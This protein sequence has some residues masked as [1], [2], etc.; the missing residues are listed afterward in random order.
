MNLF[1]SRISLK[2]GKSAPFYLGPGRVFRQASGKLVAEIHVSSECAKKL[3]LRARRW[4]RKSSVNNAVIFSGVFVA[5][6]YNGESWR[7]SLVNVKI[8]SVSSTGGVVTLPLSWVER[9]ID[10][11][12]LDARLTDE[13]RIQVKKYAKLE[14][15]GSYSHSFTSV[16]K[17]RLSFPANEF[18]TG[19]TAVGDAKVRSFSGKVAANFSVGGANFSIYPDEGER[20]VLRG[21]GCLSSFSEVNLRHLYSAIEYA[22]GQRVVVEEF[23]LFNGKVNRK[24]VLSVNYDV[25][26]STRALHDASG[27]RDAECW[28]ILNKF[29]EFV[30]ADLSQSRANLL[31]SHSLLLDAASAPIE[32]RILA[33]C[34]SIEGLAS[35]LNIRPSRRFSKHS[36]RALKNWLK[37]LKAVAKQNKDVPKRVYDRVMQRIDS[38][39]AQNKTNKLS[40]FCSG[41]GDAKG[42]Y[43]LWRKWRHPVAHGD[44]LS[45]EMRARAR[46]DHE[47]LLGLFHLIVRDIIG[48]RREQGV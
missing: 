41:C 28:H 21:E 9:V 11:R 4:S 33:L 24:R 10:V 45:D 14:Q 34:T 19:N 27:V 37:A 25:I 15:D 23:T 5:R 7:S 8:P 6:G 29:Y 12:R 17:G 20:T 16:I 3:T 22:L 44:Q 35:K 32:V 48:Y 30:S 18:V 38:P 36:G 40:T 31:S 42:L 39:V 2:D 1:C 43:S 26:D 13:Q 47:K 46:A